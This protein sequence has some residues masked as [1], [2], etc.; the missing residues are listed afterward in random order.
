MGWSATTLLTEAMFS[1]STKRPIFH[2]EADFQHALAW[3]IQLAHPQAS[4]RLEKRVATRPNIELDLLVHL[5]G[6]RLGAELKYPRRGMV[7]DVDGEH[8]ML[9]TGADD[10]S[11]YFAV[12]DLARL[13]RLVAENAIDDGALVFL[14]NVS[15]VWAPPSS[16]RAVL[17][18]AFRIH[19]GQ[20]LTGTLAWGEWGA[21]GGRP[22]GAKG[23]VVL[24]G[25]Y[26]LVW[27]DYSTVAGVEFR[28]LVVGVGSPDR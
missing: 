21:P 3:E 15:N 1:L 14:T 6:A 27:R 22:S 18:D 10:H 11:R 16:R 25:S 2:S 8:F 12:E 20:V 13:E 26:P 19:D 4:I 9:S 28:Y 7:A 24:V 17:Y 5:D 23:T